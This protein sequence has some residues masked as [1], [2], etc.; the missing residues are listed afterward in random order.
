MSAFRVGVIAGNRRY[1]LRLIE[2]NASLFEY[3]IH[4]FNGFRSHH[5][6]RTH[7]INLQQRRRVSGTESGNTCAQV[8]LIVAFVLRN[9]FVV[10]IGGIKALR[11]RINFF[12]QFAFH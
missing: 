3:F 6:C 4:R 9:N 2:V 7:F 11:Q 1:K 5:R 12:T 10:G 8:L